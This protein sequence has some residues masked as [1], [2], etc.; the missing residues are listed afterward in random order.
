M[1]HVQF[2]KSTLEKQTFTSASLVFIVVERQ[3]TWPL[4]YDNILHGP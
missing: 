4:M 1:L 3:T 2:K